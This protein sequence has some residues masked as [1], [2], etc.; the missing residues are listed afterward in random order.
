[1]LPV[2]FNGYF[3]KNS[4][5]HLHNTRSADNLHLSFSNTALRLNSIKNA[6]P[7][8]WNSLPNYLKMA[9]SLP[10]FNYK[11]KLLLLMSYI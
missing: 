4:T 9:C 6:G 11:T 2:N 1:M 7:R 3:V 5:I 8:I 10:V